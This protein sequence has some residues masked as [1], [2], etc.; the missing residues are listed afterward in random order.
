MTDTI[1]EYRQALVPTRVAMILLTSL[2]S[3][4]LTACPHTRGDDPFGFQLTHFDFL[5]SP[6]ACG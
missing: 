2:F 3:M 5:L 1:T 6:Y 4:L